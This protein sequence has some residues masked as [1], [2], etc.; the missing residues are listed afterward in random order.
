MSADEETG[1]EHPRA[2]WLAPL[3][4]TSATGRHPAPRARA[5]CVPRELASC[6]QTL[7]LVIRGEFAQTWSLDLGPPLQATFGAALN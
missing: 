6:Y 3:D 2:S 1:I 7:M 4:R 5:L